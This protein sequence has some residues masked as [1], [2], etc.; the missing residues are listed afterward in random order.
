L[1]RRFIVRNT[2][3]FVAT[4]NSI[5]EDLLH[6]DVDRSKVVV[7]PNG[8]RLPP[9]MSGE[10]PPHR[11]RKALFLGRMA[12][13]KNPL[14]LARAAL[15]VAMVR[16]VSVDFWGRGDLQSELQNVIAA[17]GQQANVR[18]CGFTD[19][20]GSLLGQY[21]FLLIASAAEGLSNS[22]LEAMAHGVVPVATRV[23]GCIDH[24]I[25]G[26][27]GFYLEGTD[28]D[29]LVTGLKQVAEVQFEDW[30]AMSQNVQ[31]YAY[32]RFDMQ[33]VVQS[34]LALYADLARTGN[35]AR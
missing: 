28:H 18:Y 15:D 16:G 22:M 33:N 19:D 23:S 21:G 14:A 9:L 34:Y 24:I 25:P 20:P 1:G 26:V 27:T 4:T 3:R 6:Y 30:L 35:S 29:S 32:E 17:A 31:T 8:L 13:D 10:H 11:A 2:D 7:I 5:V 12:A